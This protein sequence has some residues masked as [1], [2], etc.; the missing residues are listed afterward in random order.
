MRARL[1]R[2]ALCGIAAVATACVAT[3]LSVPPEHPASPGAS[4]APLPEAPATLR[5]G[6]DPDPPPEAGTP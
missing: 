1:R 5:P 2:W 6:F 4:S 3:T